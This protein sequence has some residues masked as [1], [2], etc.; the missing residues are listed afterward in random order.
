M[1]GYLVVLRIRD[2]SVAWSRTF[3]NFDEKPLLLSVNGDNVTLVTER[4]EF[5]FTRHVVERRSLQTGNV[6]WRTPIGDLL[7]ALLPVAIGFDANRNVLVLSQWSSSLSMRNPMVRVT[8]L[9][10]QTGQQTGT[11]ATTRLNE[12]Q[13][14][15]SVWTYPGDAN[16]RV[17]A[18]NRIT[19][20]LGSFP[21][22][23][24]YDGPSLQ[25]VVRQRYTELKARPFRPGG[26]M[27][28]SDDLAVGPDGSLGIALW[29]PKMAAVAKLDP[30]GTLAWAR[31]LEP[32]WTG[33]FPVG[34]G[35][36]IAV[37]GHY[38]TMA[39]PYLGPQDL[40]RLNGTTGLRGWTVPIRGSL[41]NSYAV[42]T[43]DGKVLLCP[44][45][46][47]PV[48][49]LIDPRTGARVWRAQM[50]ETP[51]AS[52]PY[53]PAVSFF[54]SPT[55]PI[56]Q[57]SIGRSSFLID[58][59]NIG[60]VEGGGAP[61][62]HLA[63]TAEGNYVLSQVNRRSGDIPLNTTIGVLSRISGQMLW[64]DN[65][66]RGE[67][68]S[69]EDVRVGGTKIFVLGRHLDGFSYVV[70]CFTARTGAVL[71]SRRIEWEPT[72][73]F[74]GVLLMTARED[75]LFLTGPVDR[76][77]G[78]RTRLLRLDV[79]T[80]ATVWESSYGDEGSTTVPARLVT[81]PDGNPVVLVYEQTAT[82]EGYRAIKFAK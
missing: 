22:V 54:S 52:V 16:Q 55:G 68:R 78:S 15:T 40:V 60:I 24:E 29:H 56:V 19:D 8:R 13:A 48:F 72:T 57:Y 18:T 39:A 23:I 3:P 64:S 59:A 71:F 61:L 66:V 58:L 1:I 53:E 65:L 38:Y 76:G 7:S 41:A 79:N 25:P 43:P 74:P 27:G 31:M 20:L 9:D 14:P 36:I 67:I 49:V 75:G 63:H 12:A 69:L 4:K 28:Q 10:G 30:D 70:R 62:H 26:P 80:G 42:G 44:V 73:R 32:S 11:G 17:M 37:R 34:R 47:P 21:E 82:G 6:V 35:Q 46:G 45:T 50:S 33:S 2:G 77:S 5:L 51:I 81:M